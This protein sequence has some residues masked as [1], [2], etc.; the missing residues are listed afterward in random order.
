MSKEL[1]SSEE[2][3]KKIQEGNPLSLVRYGDG[4]SI[5]LNGWKDVES[6]KAVFKRQ[7]GYT[8]QIDQAEEI[9]ENLISAYQ[10]AD[11]LG[12][13]LGKKIKDVD[14]YWFKSVDIL[15]EE[16]GINLFKTK[17]ELTSIDIHS[18]FLDK[19]Y[20]DLILNNVETLNYISC[21]DLDERFKEKFN[22]KTVNSFFI[23]PEVKFTTNKTGEKHY[24]ERFNKVERW[25][26]KAI[27][28]EGVI[29]L[30]GAGIAGKIY[31]NWFR[32]RGGIAID[33][34]SVFDS[35]YGRDTRG[36]SR[37]HNSIDNTYKL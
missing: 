11:I 30:V 14:S 4:E 27:N 9:R 24:P 18:D 33:I 28:C 2:V 37:G 21:R 12:V 17:K 22:I 16:A 23:P 3:L 1:L 15:H 31:C 32:D 10:N 29:C 26:D 36:P 20:Y 34:G 7:F 8:P 6:L 25:M 35:W 19:G 13:P 5:V